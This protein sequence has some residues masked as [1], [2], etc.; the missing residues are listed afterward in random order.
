MQRADDATIS[1]GSADHPADFFHLVDSRRRAFDALRSAVRGGRPGPVFVTGESGAGKTA[2]VRR[3]AAEDPARWCTATVDLAAEMN[4]LEFLRLV[5]HGLGVRSGSRLGKAR[6]RLEARLASEAAEGR[7]SML[8]V[9]RADRGRSG[10]WDEVQSIANQLGRPSGFAALVIV[11][12]TGLA[13]SL[14]SR[15]SSMGLVSQVRTHIHLKPLDLDEARDLLDSADLADSADHAMLEELHRDSHG[16]TAL[17]LRLAQTSSDRHR[18]LARSGSE[19]FDRTSAHGS[20]RRR[21]A[22]PQEMSALSGEAQPSSSGEVVKHQGG[23]TTRVGRGSARS[24]VPAV[25]PSKPP[26]RDEEGLVEVGWEGDLEDE[27]SV[28][29]SSARDSATLVSDLTPHHDELFGD[30]YQ[31]LEAQS[32]LTPNEAWLTT[33]PAAYPGELSEGLPHALAPAEAHPLPPD[34]ASGIPP[35][36]IRAEGQHEFA[37]YS[38]L[39]TRYRQSK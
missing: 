11:G 20:N 35:G 7:R 9:D 18:T 15:R 33:A 5:G 10:V 8:V 38:Q 28:R 29:E 6:L 31:A 1:I 22:G 34:S 4:A 12:I 26:I 39:F 21:L 2:L 17:L 14:A 24:E 27:P 16:N 23:T 37:P 36:G 25:I 30:H 32:Q 13:R 3:L 19:R